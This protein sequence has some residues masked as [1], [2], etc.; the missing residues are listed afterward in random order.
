MTKFALQYQQYLPPFQAYELLSYEGVF[1]HE[2]VV[3]FTQELAAVLGGEKPK[4]LFITTIELIQNIKNYS[5]E[6]IDLAGNSPAGVGFAGVYSNDD[7]F[8]SVS[9]NLVKTDQVE[10]IKAHCAKVRGQTVQELRALYNAQ[11]REPPPEGSKGAGL[12]FID[13][14]IKTGGQVDF[15]FTPINDDVT[16]FTISAF[17]NKL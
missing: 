8:I 11:L 7:E 13:I 3:Q 2:V 1:T 14:A 4:K 10:R 15:E 9:G 6:M 16:F 12:G 5:A 17:I